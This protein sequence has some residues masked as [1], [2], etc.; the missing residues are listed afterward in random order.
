LKKE[1]ANLNEK[2]GVLFIFKGHIYLI[3]LVLPKADR[4]IK[5][6]TIRSETDALLKVFIYFV[7][8]FI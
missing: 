6:F 4:N 1:D 3:L 5:R 7:L 2:M 8:N